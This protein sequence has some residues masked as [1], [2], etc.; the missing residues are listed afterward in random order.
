MPHNS[1]HPATL[2]A[3]ALGWTD[4][5]T[6]ALVMPLHTATTFERDPD[7]Q[8]RRSRSYARVGSAAYDQPQAMIS[9]RCSSIVKVKSG[10]APSR[11]R[12]SAP[13]A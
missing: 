13:R 4:A 6:G 7:N 2:A 3:Q 9:A 12:A 5:S 11:T 1:L 10:I 8:Y